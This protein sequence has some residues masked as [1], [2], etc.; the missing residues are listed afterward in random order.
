MVSEFP[1]FLKSAAV[2]CGSYPLMVFIDGVDMMEDM[3]QAKNMEWLPMNIP[4][5][6]KGLQ[7]RQ[8]LT[9]IWIV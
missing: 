5:V 2:Q 8:N 4:E 3:H 7:S 1:E 9:R 6:R